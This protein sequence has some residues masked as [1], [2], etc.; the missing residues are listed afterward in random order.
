ML[1]EARFFAAPLAVALSAGALPLLL[2][3]PGSATIGVHFSFV[4]SALWIIIVVY[5]FGSANRRTPHL[6]W[7]LP[8]ALYWPTMALVSEAAC[9]LGGDCI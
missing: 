2:R 7:G 9:Q 6:L 1:S 8:F 3:G 5:G 4:L